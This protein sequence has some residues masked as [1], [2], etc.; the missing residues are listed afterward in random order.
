[1]RVLVT[2]GAGFIGSFLVDRLL[3]A[4]HTV[5][6]L[7]ALDPQAH[8]HGPRAYLAPEAE[9]RVGDIRDRGACDAALGGVDVVVHAAAAVGVAQSLYRVEHYLDVNVRGTATLLDAI[10]ARGGVERLVV[11]TS[12][13][14]YGE[15]P[16]RRPSDGRV[17]R[18][19]ARSEPDILQWGWEPVCPETH[20]ALVAVPTPEDAELTGRNVYA[21]TKRYQ[22]ELTLSLGAVYGFP[23]LCLRLFNVYGPRQSLA[24]PYTG[25]VAIFLSRLLTGQPP[26]VYEDGGQ[27]RDFISV[28]DV[29]AA[30]AAA[31]ERPLPGTGVVNIGSGVPRRIED[32][33]R[34][35]AR[36]AGLPDVEPRVTGQFRRGDIRHC[37]ADVHRARAWLGFAPRVS[38][39]AGIAEL[40]REAAERPVRDGL[41]GAEAELRARA[42]LTERLPAPKG[43]SHS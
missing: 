42:L 41:A 9:L 12:M 13:T 1:M 11:L 34:A 35:L 26:V 16:Y 10:A 14:A 29:T 28:H 30:V 32:V 20:E 22:E 37:F 18:V 33:A 40:A 43:V 23:V 36:V 2:G 5:R 15:G 3:I 31:I 27:T 39:E 25:V 24:N 8:P 38:W 7:D 21:L 4:G 19:A 17:Q 6:V